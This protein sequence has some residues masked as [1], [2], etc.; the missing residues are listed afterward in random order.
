MP[1]FIFDTSAMHVFPGLTVKLEYIM[2]NWNI[3]NPVDSLDVESELDMDETATVEEVNP[4][5][6]SSTT[7]SAEHLIDTLPTDP[8]LASALE[9]PST[10]ASADSVGVG[11]ERSRENIAFPRLSP[12]VSMILRKCRFWV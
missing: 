8:T 4:Q 9:T 7:H 1:T 11:I 6:P 3:L 5:A 2:L 10:G 12:K